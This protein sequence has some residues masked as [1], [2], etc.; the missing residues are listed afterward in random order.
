[1]SR[2][3][4]HVRDPDLQHLDIYSYLALKC[5]LWASVVS[6]MRVLLRGTLFHQPPTL[7]AKS[8]LSLMA[9]KKQLKTH[10]SA[11]IAVEHSAFVTVLL[12]KLRQ[13]LLLL[14]LLLFLLISITIPQ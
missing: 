4:Q 5:V 1:M 14:L 9:L 11:S 3:F 10:Y 8:L 12:L 7:P 13:C 6:A 2:W